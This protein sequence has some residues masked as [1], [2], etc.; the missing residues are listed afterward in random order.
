MA[1]FVYKFRYFIIAAFVLLTL[2]AALFIP[3]LRFDGDI[4][5]LAPTNISSVEEYKSVSQTFGG[6]D[7]LAF[8]AQSE[9][10]FTP[11]ALSEA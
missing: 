4:Q 8:S 5:A 3:N 7:S 6:A 10:L 11:E 2:V 1:K 9:H